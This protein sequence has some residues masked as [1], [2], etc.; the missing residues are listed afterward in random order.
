M[1]YKLR[2]SLQRPKTEYGRKTFKQRAEIT[3]N[4]LPESG[5]LVH[6]QEHLTKHSRSLDLVTFN[7]SLK[8]LKTRTWTLS[9]IFSNTIYSI[10]FIG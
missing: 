4:M 6:L 5:K 3:W 1:R 10:G 7:N 9:I 2:S 8:W